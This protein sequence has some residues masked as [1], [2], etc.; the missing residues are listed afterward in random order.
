MIQAVDFIEAAKAHGFLLYTGVP[1]SYLKPFINYVIDSPDTHYV[2][3]ANEGDAVAIGA[4]SELG[5]KPAVVMLQNS[6][7]GNAVNS[8]SSLTYIF[9]IPVLLIITLRGDPDG[10]E[11][12]PQHQLMG[13]MTT[14]L[15]DLLQIPWEYFPT[16]ANEISI[17]IDRAKLF[18]DKQCTPYAMVMKKGAVAP[19]PMTSEPLSRSFCRLIEG[20]NGSQPR[21][22][23]IQILQTIHAHTNV[24]DLIVA[25][26]GYTGREL[27]AL[28]DRDN[29]LYM[30]G[31]M[32]CAASLGLG[33]ALASP[34]RRVIII[35]GDGALLM[36]LGVLTTIGYEQP[37]NL[38][39]IVLDNEQYESTGG[40]STSSHAVDF[41]AIAA[42]SS[43][44]SV[45]CADTPE[46]LGTI[47][48]VPQSGP[49]FVLVKIKPG[50]CGKLIRP[51]V[52]PAQVAVRMRLFLQS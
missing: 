52:T 35:D 26:T 14:S 17:A 50:T 9:K 31:S 13:A 3:A 33:L 43:Y 39:H 44:T 11:D 34:Q 21:P 18:M 32:G 46:M 4:G 49:S 24:N 23:R 48:K 22:T 51:T 38:L 5:G 7:L 2:G 42:A 47:M 45:T 29:Q 30:V 19:W 25:T 12:E 20:S 1:C 28:G 40:Q 15:L 27:Y 16:E 10:A 8:L 37:A 6:G 36:H 41:C